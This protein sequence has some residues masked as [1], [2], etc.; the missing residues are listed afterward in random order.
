MIDHSAR[1]R[2]TQVVRAYL[3]DHRRDMLRDDA[4]FTNLTTG[5][6]WVGRA[7]IERML[8][9][10]YS[11]ALDATLVDRRVVVEG[12]TAV[13]HGSVVGRH[14]G[15]LAGVAPTDR[16]VRF[17]LFVVYEVEGDR[18]VRGEFLF[19]AAALRAQVDDGRAEPRADQRGGER[20]A[21]PTHPSLLE[22]DL[23]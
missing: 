17:D 9:W 18:I 20:I 8:A 13:L 16:D 6:Q 15:E 22:G 21:G 11:E 3:D 14:I 19:D 2:T 10:F 23:R 12:D 4:V 1:E 5:E 7:A